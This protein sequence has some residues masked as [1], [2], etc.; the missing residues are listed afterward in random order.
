VLRVAVFL[1]G[2]EPCRL[3]RAGLFPDQLDVRR[4]G[5]LEL[6]LEIRDV[7][8]QRVLLADRLVEVDLSARPLMTQQA[9]F[10]A[11]FVFTRGLMLTESRQTR[12]HWHG[13]VWM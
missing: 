8:S 12:A 5:V 4:A 13:I 6:A 7:P 10:A 3:G 11:R 9:A 2:G 1:F